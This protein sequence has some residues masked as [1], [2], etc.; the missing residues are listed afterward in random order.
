MV[1]TTTLGD[2]VMSS[3]RFIDSL[4]PMTGI[5]TSRS[6]TSGSSLS[7]RR[8]A[9]LPFSA[10]PMTSIPSSVESISLT[11][12][13]NMAWSS[14]SST[15]IFI[16]ASLLSPAVPERKKNPYSRDPFRGGVHPGRAVQQGHAF[17]YGT[18]TEAPFVLAVIPEAAAVVL[19]V[20]GDLLPGYVQ[21][22]P[23]MAAAR[24]PNRVA[25][26]PPQ[27]HVELP[28]VVVR[29]QRPRSGGGKISADFVGHGDFQ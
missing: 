21:P 20:T 8:T 13:R 24:V 19:D 15:L 10:S 14:A 11:P 5:S 12:W 22:D 17:L 4:A 9:S 6:T 26:G 27:D 25:D 1:T 2:G 18:E 29:E 3:I 28:A 23:E 16:S 7:A